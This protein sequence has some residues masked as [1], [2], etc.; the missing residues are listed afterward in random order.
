MQYNHRFVCFPI[1]CWCTYVLLGSVWHSCPK[2]A[3]N[4]LWSLH[5]KG[6]RPLVYCLYLPVSMYLIRKL[7][8]FISPSGRRP[9]HGSFCISYFL[10]C[11][12]LHLPSSLRRM[13]RAHTHF[14]VLTTFIV[15]PTLV[16]PLINLQFY[17]LFR[18][19][20]NIDL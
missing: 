2:A 10:V 1:F 20:P 19:I 12:F 8:N 11:H 18:M 4:I 3:R 7:R 14:R 13:C 5:R 16:C 9:P 6:C 17:L 15:S